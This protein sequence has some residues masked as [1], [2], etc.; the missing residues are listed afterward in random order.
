MTLLRHNLIAAIGLL[1][2]APVHADSPASPASEME[3]KLKS[4][5]VSIEFNNAKIE[6]ATATLAALSKRLDPEHKGVQFVIQPNAATQAKAI[7]LNLQNVPLGEALRYACELGSV[8]YKIGEHSISIVPNST[9]SGLVQ[10]TFYVDPA[11]VKAAANA[12][13]I[14]APKSP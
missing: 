9:E 14:P 5:V 4:I 1:S 7:T 2:L 10:R 6:E 3:Q 13:A 12:G 11:F 8:H